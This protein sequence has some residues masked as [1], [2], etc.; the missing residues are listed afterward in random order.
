MIPFG[1]HKLWLTIIH[2]DP[3]CVNCGQTFW[4]LNEYVK[5]SHSIM[6]SSLPD[7]S[8]EL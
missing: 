7:G 2:Q 3:L 8:I 4:C 5:K 6:E 1:Y